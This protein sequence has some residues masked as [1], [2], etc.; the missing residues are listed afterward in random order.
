MYSCFVG[1]LSVESVFLIIDRLM[2]YNSTHF[3]VVVAL[4]YFKYYEKGLLEITK[5]EEIEELF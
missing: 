2:G 4:S 5:E 3:L 1:V